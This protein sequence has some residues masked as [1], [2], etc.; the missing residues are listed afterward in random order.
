MQAVIMAGGKGTRLVSVTKD[1]IPKP[2]VL[3]AG[4][5]L[6]LWQIE[7]LKKNGIEDIVIVIG[8]LGCKIVEFFGEGSA[9]GVHIAYIQERVP[10]GTAGALYEFKKLLREPYFLLVFGDIF[11]AVDIHRMEIFHQACKA[12]ATLLVH[13]NGHPADSDLVVLDEEDR[14]IRFDA[15]N[16][17]RSGWY[18]NCVNA[19]LYILD[20]SICGLVKKDTK[21]DLEKEILAPLAGRKNKIYGYYSTEYIRDIGTVERTKQT[22]ADIADGFIWRRCLRKKQKCIFLCK[23]LLYQTE[24][25]ELAE[26]A[27]QAVYKM[28]HSEYLV[29]ALMNQ[30]AVEKGLCKIGDVEDIHKKTAVLLGNEGAYLDAFF[31]FPHRSQAEK[32]NIDLSQS[33]IAGNTIMDIQTGVNAGM[34][35]AFILAGKEECDRNG[36]AI[37][38]LV[39]EDLLDAV[40]I[41]LQGA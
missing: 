36:Q 41:I 7:E 35:T 28:N 2:M 6:L 5:P 26:G 29:I 40:Q 25:F 34:H 13:P 21:M 10:L 12:E 4:K 8:H 19:G 23:G 14:V 39:C 33:W 20:E 37:P 38:E 16:H 31:Y 1:A 22:E 3:L 27:A 24:G 32:Y 30:T 17:I 9:F 11:F 15:K 18:D